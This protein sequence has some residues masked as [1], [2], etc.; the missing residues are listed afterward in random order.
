MRK[1]FDFHGGVHPLENKHQSVRTAIADAGIP[2]ELVI[3]LSQHIGAPSNP[4]VGVGDHVRK[5]QVIAEALGF[6][7]VPKHAP[8]SG[9]IR[10]REL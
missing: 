6:V 10:M 4:V 9:T 3:P 7:S 1:V 8:S 2:P 5:G